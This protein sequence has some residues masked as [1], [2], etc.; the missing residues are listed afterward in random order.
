MN[1]PIPDKRRISATQFLEDRQFSTLP[2]SYNRLVIAKTRNVTRENLWQPFVS[3]HSSI[4]GRIHMIWRYELIGANKWK[5]STYPDSDMVT[6]FPVVSN[7]S[8][9]FRMVRAFYRPGIDLE[10][11]PPMLVFSETLPKTAV[12]SRGIAKGQPNYL[13]VFIR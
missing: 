4:S 9:L 6:I 2:I 11:L 12:R 5:L 8:S 1:N 3:R 10:S 13:S 7:L